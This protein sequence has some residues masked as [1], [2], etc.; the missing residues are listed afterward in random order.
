MYLA[1]LRAGSIPKAEADVEGRPYLAIGYTSN[2]T[3]WTLC[4]FFRTQFPRRDVV[5]KPAW[6]P[7]LILLKRRWRDV[8]EALSA[9]SADNV[10]DVSP[11]SCRSTSQTG[12][13][14]RSAT[15][16]SCSLPSPNCRSN[17]RGIWFISAFTPAGSCREVIFRGTE[18]TE[19]KR[20]VG[21][22]EKIDATNQRKVIEYEFLQWLCSVGVRARYWVGRV[23]DASVSSIIRPYESHC[24]NVLW[25]RLP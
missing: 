19:N 5:N 3:G 9:Y 13:L 11:L 8:F 16:D 14:P 2:L 18:R 25:K 15:D 1:V 20:T 22:L 10:R 4:F 21:I 6:H 7:I 12:P 24:P 17:S 23:P